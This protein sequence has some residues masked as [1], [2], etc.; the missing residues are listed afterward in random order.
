MEQ[1]KE[2]LTDIKSMNMDELTEFIISLGEKKFR[3]KQIYEWIHVQLGEAFL[4]DSVTGQIAALLFLEGDTG[5]VLQNGGAVNAGFLGDGITIHEHEGDIGEF[6]GGHAQSAFL[7]EA[8][9]DNHLGAV[10]HG[11]LHGLVTVENPKN[12][13]IMNT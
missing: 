12:S 4:D 13:V 7:H 5:N 2:Q 10:L 8:G 3:A 1:I 9:A 6:L 11:G